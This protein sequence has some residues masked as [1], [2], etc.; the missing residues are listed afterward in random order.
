MSH[1]DD[2]AFQRAILANSADTTLKLIY[3][4]WLE[5]R[6]DPRAEYVRLQMAITT[7][8]LPRNKAKAQERRLRD[9]DRLTEIGRSLDPVWITFMQ[10][11]AQPFVPFK[12]NWQEPDHPFTETVGHRGNLVVFESQ[13]RTADTWNGGLLADARFVAAGEW[14]ECAYGAAD[15]SMYGFVCDLLTEGDPLTARDVL[16]AI[17]A[18]NF[19][20]EHVANLNVTEMAFPGYRPGTANDEI[21]TE[22]AEQHMFMNNAREG[23]VDVEDNNTHG[24]KSYVR[25]RLWYVLLH[26]GEKPCPMVALL[27]VGRSPH[28]NRLVGTITRQMC[29]NLCD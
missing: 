15:F 26:I 29:H 14:L 4:D 18:A 28:G 27:A 24:L 16:T 13:Y 21:H 12:L 3:A 8:P 10:T 5:E 2:I 25:G 17:K 11:L 20:C 22:F 9:R 1:N 6:S 23:V 19:R 7:T